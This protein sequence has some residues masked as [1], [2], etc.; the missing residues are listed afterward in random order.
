MQLS[1][2]SRLRTN[3]PLTV[4]D[5]DGRLVHL[6]NHHGYHVP[7]HKKGNDFTLKACQQIVEYATK[8]EGPVIITGDF[9]LEPDSESIE[10]INAHFRNFSSL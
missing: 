7:G 8:L 6:I 10:V 2:T 4:R 9:N 3:R 1:V 5:Q